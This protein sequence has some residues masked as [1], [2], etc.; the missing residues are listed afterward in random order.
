[1]KT[2]PVTVIASGSVELP[3]SGGS[4]GPLTRHI[5]QPGDDVQAAIDLAQASTIRRI[6]I[7]GGT[8]ELDEP[9]LITGSRVEIDMHANATLRYSGPDAAV[10]FRNAKD[11]EMH[12]GRILCLDQDA[13]GVRI[14]QADTG[15]TGDWSMR[16]KVHGGWIRNDS[17]RRPTMPTVAG[18]QSCGVRIV[19][20]SGDPNAANY[21]H[22]IESVRF[23]E[24]D[25]DAWI[26][27]FCNA[28]HLVRN[29]YE[30][31]WYGVVL[32]AIEC[33]IAGGF[34]HKIPGTDAQRPECIR[35]GDASQGINAMRNRIG[36]L[37][38]EPGGQ[39]TYGLA[40]DAGSSKNVIDVA[41]NVYRGNRIDEPDN[42]IID[43]KGVAGP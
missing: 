6:E 16:V 7:V 8:Y 27:E 22:V 13:D 28:N 4:T 17:L 38:M 32:L 18:I 24:W 11:C 9:L 14:E 2:Y 29:W 25:A 20:L 1:M 15:S 30:T 10:V 5:V 42:V 34:F 37:T 19:N 41:P 31:A 43:H 3:E 40:I 39:W 35:L 12:V 33:Q 36:G 23:D 21:G 26:G